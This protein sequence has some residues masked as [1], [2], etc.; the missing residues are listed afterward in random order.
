M[1]SKTDFQMNTDWWKREQPVSLAKGKGAKFLAA[2]TTVV[3]S[4]A[5]LGKA[6]KAKDQEEFAE[7][8]PLLEAAL[9][10]IEKVGKEVAA[11]VRTL[12]KSAGDAKLRL[13]LDNT[14]AV[15]G[16]PLARVIDSLRGGLDALDTEDDSND[17]SNAEAYKAYLKKMMPKLKKG[18]YSFAIAMPSA[19]PADIRMRVHRTKEG[20]ALATALRKEIGTAKFC[21]G[22]A[23]AEAQVE[24]AEDE[25]NSTLIL[26]LDSKL[27][28]GL[29]KKLKQ[30]FGAMESTTFKKVKILID[31]E[32]AET[33]ETPEG[34]VR[35]ADDEAGTD[36]PDLGQDEP[37]DQPSTAPEGGEGGE[38]LNP[39]FASYQQMKAKVVPLI[40]PAIQRFPDQREAFAKLVKALAQAEQ[41]GRYDLGI[42]LL[43][44]RIVPLLKSAQ[45]MAGTSGGDTD[46]G[47]KAPQ[48]T[49]RQDPNTMLNAGLQ[50][51]LGRTFPPDNQSSWDAFWSGS[52]KKISDGGDF[53]KGVKTE[54]P[55]DSGYA[56]SEQARAWAINMATLQHMQTK[57]QPDSPEAKALMK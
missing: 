26:M 30:G 6:I 2:M 22:N 37:E 19:S 28:P 18:A 10:E 45:R 11:E 34:E 1:K 50:K 12:L 41:A 5:A 42:A 21:W 39:L 16:K 54:F 20:K 15:M 24:N 3:R 56:N 49:A 57:V 35:P 40:G 52:T 48:P 13:D 23:A 7:V 43:R 32:E 14:L 44:D 17:L 51:V 27:I 38:A 55:K 53:L 46:L 4:N 36:L 8:A 47:T 25:K 31:G 9:D 29:A 33:D